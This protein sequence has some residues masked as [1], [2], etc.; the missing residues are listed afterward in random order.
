MTTKG[1][2]VAW[3]SSIT[4]LPVEPMPATTVWPWSFRM[5]FFIMVFLQALPIRPSTM[6]AVM[7]D[8][9]NATEPRPSRMVSTVTP[10]A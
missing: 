7:A 1:V 4:C 9:K 5:A 3:S 6:T 2:P 10:R 8:W